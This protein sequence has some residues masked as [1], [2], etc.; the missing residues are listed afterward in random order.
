MRPASPTSIAA[1]SACSPARRVPPPIARSRCGCVP[2][3]CR[4]I[5]RRAFAQHWG[6]CATS[7][8]TCA[9]SASTPRAPPASSRG[10]TRS[11]TCRASKRRAPIRCRTSMRATGTGSS[12]CAAFRGVSARSRCSTRC[13]PDRRSISTARMALHTCERTV[14]ATSCSWAAARGSR[15]CFR[16]RAGPCARPRQRAAHPRIPW[17]AHAA[18]P[19]RTGRVLAAARLR[20]APGL[21]DGGSR[22]PSPEPGTDPSDSSTSTC[23]PSSVSAGTLSIT[24]SPVRPPWLRRCNAC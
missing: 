5:G 14:R 7:P 15:P 1:S 24:I 4:C 17:R 13:R 6:V 18:R 12:S 20:F 19:M 11:S 22:R 21:P 9:N 10:S 23:G 3:T 16:S 2:T 8:T